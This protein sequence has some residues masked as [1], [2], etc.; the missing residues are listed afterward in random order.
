[1]TLEKLLTQKGLV[2]QAPSKA[3]IL[4]RAG[5][6]G[7]PLKIF[8]GETY[9]EEGNPI[10]SVKY[11]FF[12]SALAKK[13]NE[14]GFEA[15]PQILIADVA[16]CR[17]VGE[18][19]NVRYV[20]LGEKRASFVKELNQEYGLG[21]EVIKMSDYLFGEEFQKKV[22]EV[23]AICQADPRLMEMVERSVPESK[24][25][26]ERKKGFAYSFDEIAT[27]IDL[28]VKVGPP[29]EDL[30]DGIAREVANRE[31][32]PGLMSLFLTPTF[33]VGKDFDYFLINEGIEDHG[34][35]AYKAG[36]KRLQDNRVIVGRT[37][38]EQAKALI[39]ASFISPNPEL[40]NP[41]LDLGM[42]CEMARK[43]KTGEDFPITLYDDFYSGKITPDELKLKVEESLYNN[44]LE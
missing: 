42:I 17:N 2:K 3:E 40:P 16:A 1:M 10:D 34:I 9:D 6:V 23:R 36:S 44:F 25:D 5:Q 20:N 39:D 29:R 22:A 38:R 33:P 30:Y 18:S 12:V 24:I 19:L 7:R 26:I 14:E 4:E 35:T 8:Y 37:T 32:K 13:I 31:G 11:Y 28:D 41:V 21:L 27:I 15:R 43:L